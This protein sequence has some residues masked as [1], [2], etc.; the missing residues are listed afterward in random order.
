MSVRWKPLII[1][2]GL[3]LIIAVFGLLAITMDLAPGGAEILPKAR[4]EWKAGRYASAQ[5]HFL[6]AL[7]KDPRNA[8]IHEE[9]A[10]LYADWAEADPAKRDGL[11]AERLSSLADAAKFGKSAEPR[12]QLLQVALSQDDPSQCGLWA[13]KLLEVDRRAPDAHYALA[14]AALD[15]ATPD[16]DAAAGHLEILEQAEPDRPRTQ[17]LLARL[18]E[19]SADSGAVAAILERCRSAGPEA[20]RDATDR[21]ALLRLRKLDALAADDPERLAARCAAMVELARSSSESDHSSTEGLMAIGRQL[22]EVAQHLQRVQGSARG[23]AASLDAAGAALVEL[24]EACFRKALEGSNSADL[25]IYQEYAEQLL[26]RSQLARCLELVGTALKQPSAKLPAWTDT[27]MQLREIAI[28]AALFDG[29]DPGRFAGAEPHIQELLKSASAEHQA[30]GHLFQ[31]VIELDRSGLAEAADGGKPATDGD[32]RLRASALG[33][34]KLAAAG[35]PKAATA[36]AL[37]GVALMLTGEPALGRQYLIG[38]RNLPNLEPRYRLWCAWAMLQAGY[39]EEAEPDVR[40]LISGLADGRTPRDLEPSLRLLVGEIHQARNTPDDLRRARDAYRKAIEAGQPATPSL[41]LRQAQIDVMLGEPAKGLERIANLRARG[42]GGPEAEHLAVLILSE[43]KRDA[44]ARKALDAARKQYPDSGELA[45]LDAA[46]RL[47]QDQPEQADRVLAEFLD[48][49]PK[50]LDVLQLRARLLADHLQRP[51][52]ARKLL[53]GAAEVAE[54]S[55]PLVQL[56]LIDLGRG[57]HAAVAAT[58][59]KIRGRWKEAAAADL[60]DAQLA[61]AQRDARAALRHLDEALRKDPS[62]KLALFWKAQLGDKTGASAESARIY[63]A[64]ARERPVKELDDGLSLATAANWALATMEL[65]NHEI[66]GAI[67]RLESL[68]R[69]GLDR[70]TARPVRWQLVAARA[71]SGHWPQA[72]KEMRALLAESATS[73]ERIRA[74]N[75]YRLHGDPKQAVTLLDGVLKEEPDHSAA[76]AIRAFLLAEDQPEQAAALIRRGI[77]AGKQPPSLYLM[78]AAIENMIPPPADGLKRA[79]AVVDEGLAVDADSIELVQARFRLQRM[80]GDAPGALAFVEQKAKHDPKGQF[81]RL[82]IDIHRDEARYEAAEA[83][84]LDLLEDTPRD[85]A[86]AAMHVRLV[87]FRAIEAG[88]RGDREAERS[89][90]AAT[91]DL[92]RRYRAEF[93]AEPAFLQADVELAARSGQLDRAL[94]LTQE[95]DALDNASP[96][97]PTL[98]AQIAAAR[99]WAQGVAQE[100]AEAVARAPRRADLRLALGES[101]LAVGKTDEAIRQADW[102]LQADA[103]QPAAVLLKARALSRQPGSP[104]KVRARRAEAIETLRASIRERPKFSAAY[105]QLAEIQ[106]QDGA[107]SD[108][109]RSLKSAL[110]AVPEDAAGLSLLVQVLA[111]PRRDGSP[112]SAQELEEAEALAGRYA[113]ADRTGNSALAA[114]LG[115]HKAGQLDRAMPWAEKA[116]SRLDTWVVHL[117]YGDLLLSKAEATA[118]PQNARRLFEQADA[119]YARVLKDQANSIEAINNKA[120]ILHQ[121]LDRAP[122]ALALCRGLMGRVDPSTLPPDFYDTLGSI[123]ESLH[124]PKEAEAAYAEGLR[125]AADHPILNFHMGRLVAGDRARAEMAREFLDKANAARSQLPP[126]MAAEVETLVSR[127]GR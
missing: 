99:G 111:E 25:R 124:H 112:P 26:V 121:Y 19:S 27:V 29:H 39:P 14:I 24:S 72:E 1:L 97:G 41:E 11:R 95:L 8:K 63:E 53:Q 43:Q 125:R 7:Q 110:E 52:D 23:Q 108:A 98:R 119:H 51:E 76:L 64:I 122:E 66:E 54:S 89:L 57:E 90:N 88:N 9:L 62:N 74:A 16:S 47:K 78:L 102:L 58:I 100:Y 86:L 32:P 56:A 65:E 71:A 91:A 73:E 94:T 77:A 2:S 40:T 106:L 83:I 109:A 123:E 84:V 61:L 31:G 105:H 59:A 33:H 38:A 21:M 116:A 37:Y 49:H 79:L 81:R 75:F 10:R 117:N 42:V 34:L 92:I 45:S 46:L 70:D 12:R 28:R 127:L 115:F 93:P 118:D 30:I 44:E 50:E 22:G 5:I 107:R 87:A 17:W 69:G 60:L 15:G 96:I 3:F 114:A 104:E 103:E 113:E 35:L 36:Q 80:S 4:A 68:V 13:K 48:A 101:S 6:R 85:E 67:T 120:W 18:A 126:T 82:L 55:S 20:C